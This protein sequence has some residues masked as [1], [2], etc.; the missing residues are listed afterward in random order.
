MS[1]I[2]SRSKAMIDLD[3]LITAAVC[4]QISAELA[5]IQMQESASSPP[6]CTPSVDAINTDAS[7]CLQNEDLSTQSPTSTGTGEGELTF[8]DLLDEL[9]GSRLRYNAAFQAKVFDGQVSERAREHHEAHA[10][11]K[12]HV[13]TAVQAAVVKIE[14]EAFTDGLI[15]AVTWNCA[16]LTTDALRELA[17]IAMR[18]ARPRTPVSQEELCST[19]R[20]PMSLHDTLDENETPTGSTEW[21]CDG[22]NDRTDKQGCWSV[23]AEEHSPSRPAGGAE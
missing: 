9:V 19:C 14:L 23:Q 5:L 12:A 17:P 11:I 6:K 21:V 16:Q 13:T 1:T 18:L 7:L 20:L 2:D 8:D 4:G 3:N 22:P 15:Y 10:A